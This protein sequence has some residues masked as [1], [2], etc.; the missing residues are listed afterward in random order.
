[1]YLNELLELS[2]SGPLLIAS[3]S[4]WYEDREAFV[5]VMILEEI[6]EVAAAPE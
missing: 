3:T 1:M 5:V 2:G 6:Q 4:S